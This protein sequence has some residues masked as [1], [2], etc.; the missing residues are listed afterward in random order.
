MVLLTRKKGIS[1]QQAKKVTS[2]EKP[3]YKK[4]TTRKREKKY[5]VYGY[6]KK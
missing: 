1:K 6:K 2:I 3:R 4:I 5:F